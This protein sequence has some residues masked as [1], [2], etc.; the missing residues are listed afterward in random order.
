[1]SEYLTLIKTVYLY[2]E[3]K[4]YEGTLAIMERDSE[5]GQEFIHWN[6]LD[7]P[8]WAILPNCPQF[9]VLNVYLPNP[10]LWPGLTLGRDTLYSKHDHLSN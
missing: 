5:V 8:S 6:K 4:L 9:L 10:N 2:K 7:R 1:M 3:K